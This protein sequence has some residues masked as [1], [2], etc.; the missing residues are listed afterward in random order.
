M[1]FLV[2]VSII[3]SSLLASAAEKMKMNFNNEEITKIIEMYSKETGQKFVIDPTVRGKASIFVQN[4][5]THDE[6]FNQLSIALALN[7]FAISKRGDVMAVKNARSIQRDLIEVSTK[8]PPV[9]P[10]RMY[11]WIYNVK[12]IS[13]ND[14]HKDLRLITSSYGEMAVNGKTNQLI[15][16]DW[17]SNINRIADL[18]KE[19]DVKTSPEV[20]KIVAEEMKRRD[21]YRKQTAKETKKIA[22]KKESN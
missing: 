4:E 12:N 11:T 20:A 14:L 8:V 21:A 1:K 15:L 17:T 3:A 10:E 16:T 7:G 22:D 19:V 13:A 6:A 18:M 5:V 9:S 2:V